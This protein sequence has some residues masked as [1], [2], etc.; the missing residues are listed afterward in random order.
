MEVMADILHDFK[1]ELAL[2]FVS[3]LLQPPH[4]CPTI[5]AL[6]SLSCPARTRILAH[7][8]V[9][10]RSDSPS[11]H[12]IVSEAHVYTHE[13]NMVPLLGDLFAMSA[14]LRPSTCQVRCSS[15]Q[16]HAQ[17]SHCESSWNSSCCQTAMTRLTATQWRQKPR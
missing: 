1:L 2:P 16:K 4:I 13:A 9:T 15:A 11:Y 10:N 6:S 5:K 8:D 14:S 17:T 7:R 3:W 12:S